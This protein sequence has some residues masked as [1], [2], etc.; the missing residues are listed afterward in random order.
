VRVRARA[1][2]REDGRHSLVGRSITA[3]APREIP[4]S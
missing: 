4:T 2:R 3:R 1:R